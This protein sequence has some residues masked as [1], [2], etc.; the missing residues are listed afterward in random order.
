MPCKRRGTIFRKAVAALIRDADNGVLRIPEPVKDVERL[1]F[2]LLYHG[3]NEY[4]NQVMMARLY[5]SSVPHLS[6][7]AQSLMT[8]SGRSSSGA[9]M[10]GN[11]NSL[12]AGEGTRSKSLR[13]KI[14]GIHVQILCCQSRSRTTTRGHCDISSKKTF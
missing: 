7:V 6:W 4:A 8:A 11:K 2:Y 13:K 9:L 5:L 14:K 12:G 3:L 1:H 10:P